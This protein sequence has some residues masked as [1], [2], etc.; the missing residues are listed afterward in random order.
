MNGEKFVISTL[1]KLLTFAAPWRCTLAPMPLVPHDSES[2]T[3]III[4][5]LSLQQA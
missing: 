2:N 3:T 5:I 1:P 4:I